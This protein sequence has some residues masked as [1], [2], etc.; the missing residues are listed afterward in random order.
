ME[1]PSS[2]TS[3]GARGAGEIGIIGPGAAIAGAIASAFGG[4][5]QPDRLP[6]TPPRVWA[7]ANASASASEP[8]ASSLARA[9]SG[10]NSL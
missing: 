5:V 10:L 6:V 9:H 7:L 4:G 2:V 3:T 8:V 1:T